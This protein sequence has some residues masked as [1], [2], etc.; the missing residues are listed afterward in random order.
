MIEKTKL[1]Y[2]AYFSFGE[3]LPVVS[4]HR[5]SDPESLGYAYDVAATLIADEFQGIERLFGDAIL[6]QIPLTPEMI[7]DLREAVP[8]LADGPGARGAVDWC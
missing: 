1:P 4:P 6:P 8:H 5:I 3:K 7:G 2:I